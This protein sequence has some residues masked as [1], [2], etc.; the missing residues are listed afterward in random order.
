MISLHFAAAA[1][2]TTTTSSKSSAS[3]KTASKEVN[4]TDAVNTEVAQL[5][6]QLDDVGSVFEITETKVNNLLS[7]IQARLAHDVVTACVADSD[8]RGIRVVAL[9]RDLKSKLALVGPLVSS[10]S[11]TAGDNF[12]PDF[13]KTALA[14][15][16]NNSV[17]VAVAVDELLAVREVTSLGEC[18]DSKL[19][20][21]KLE[22]GLQNLSEE[23][24]QQISIQGVAHAIECL[25]RASL[26]ADQSIRSE[27][28]QERCK[29]IIDFISE[30]QGSSIANS[31][32]FKPLGNELDF[33]RTLCDFIKS[34]ESTQESVANAE[35]A[36]TMLTTKNSIFLKCI[37]AFPLGIWM[38]ESAQERLATYHAHSSLAL[39]LTTAKLV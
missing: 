35:K 13:L 12:H 9:A 5:L 18:G 33:L 36:R 32:P 6:Q 28:G 24:R 23:S 17:P 19:L 3:T 34:D 27:A 37:T 20:V 7:K 38:M 8:E 10:I 14:S 31:D 11:A 25:M 1:G 39:G 16:R 15:C 4:K 26:P 30:W 21:G 29:T 22:G 2:G